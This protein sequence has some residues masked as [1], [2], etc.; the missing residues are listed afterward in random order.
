MLIELNIENL[1][2]IENVHLKLEPGMTVLSGEEG[3]GKSLVVDALGILLGM[4]APAKLI[5]NGK[6]QARIEAVFYISVD[7]RAHIKEILGDTDVLEHDD[8]ILVISRDIHHQGRSVSRIN[9]HALPQSF[10]RSIGQLL[11]DIHGQLDYIS[12][13]DIRHQMN[14]LDAYGNLQDLRARYAR[15]I[16]E[17]RHKLRDADSLETGKS[18]GKIELLKY[19]VEEIERAAVIPGEE[20]ELQRK[21]DLFQHAG[22]L[23]DNC[24]KIYMSL[25]GD[26]RSATVLI[27]EALSGIKSSKHMESMF[28]RYMEALNDFLSSVEDIAH[29]F[30]SA[31]DN[32]E[33]DPA[34]L[35]NIEQRLNLL[36]SLKR[37]YGPALS[38]IVSFQN[39]ALKELQGIEDS[40]DYRARLHVTIK[41][42]E[43]VSAAL[44]EE[45]SRARI[46]AAK[47]LSDLVNRE[48]E[49]VGLPLAHFSISL[50]QDKSTDGLLLSTGEKYAYT[51]DGI[52]KIEYMVCTNPGEPL[53]PL[54]TIASGGETSRI[55]LAI[56]SALKKVDPIPTLIFDE[57]DAGIGSRNGD[58]IGR[59]LSLLS[60]QH[61]V[62]CITHLPQIACFADTHIKMQKDINSGRASTTT[63]VIDGRNQVE[64]IADMLGMNSAGKS[65]L[66]GAE[67]L[68]DN[69]SAWKYADNN[70]CAL[71][72]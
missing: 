57:I 22:S 56:K 63:Q 29:V 5:R 18:E 66:K 27:H 54:R 20:E 14:L 47:S 3:S 70:K 36:N 33:M 15:V 44:S 59:K 50:D 45:L 6:N 26:D 52:D 58:N 25:Y 43:K 31:A 35:E 13:L 12:V 55:M 53:R 37:K 71:V 32:V 60:R 30:H 68:L 65:M 10:L 40:R 62:I 64:E 24:E 49:D 72:H 11:V 38:D 9:G 67:K 28:G 2:V 7:T 4:R 34:E 69:A 48:L 1:A 19:Q 61:Q 41:E 21:L 42:M 39:H 51:R 16:D 46:S 17:L 8:N 23:R